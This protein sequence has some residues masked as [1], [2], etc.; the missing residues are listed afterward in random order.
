MIKPKIN[1]IASLFQVE[2][3]LKVYI[4]LQGIE[5]EWFMVQLG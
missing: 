4:T 3:M 2:E 1:E 5:F